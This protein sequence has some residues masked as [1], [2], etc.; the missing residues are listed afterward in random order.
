MSYSNCTNTAVFLCKKTFDGHGTDTVTVIRV[1]C[2]GTALLVS[3]MQDFNL[4]VTDRLGQYKIK[5]CEA[6]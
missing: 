3:E 2:H 6:K 5:H 1:R 4:K